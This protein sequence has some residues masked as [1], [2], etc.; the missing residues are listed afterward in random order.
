MGNGQAQEAWWHKKIGPV[1]V[2]VLHASTLLLV[3]GCSVAR[4]L[5][6]VLR[7]S[8]HARSTSNRLCLKSHLTGENPHTMSNET[9]QH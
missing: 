9:I 1:D 5:S 7:V 8:Q 2:M 6:G 4:T 3:S